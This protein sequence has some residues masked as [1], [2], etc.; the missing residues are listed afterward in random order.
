MKRTVLLLTLCVT[1][2]LSACGA[3]SPPVDSSQRDALLARL[4]GLWVVDAEATPEYYLF[5]DGQIYIATQTD[6]MGAFKDI[7]V[8]TL[9]REGISAWKSLKLQYALEKLDPTSICPAVT[10][11]RID[12]DEDTVILYEGTYREKRITVSGDSVVLT[13]GESTPSIDKLSDEADFS[14]EKF[15]ALFQYARKN[16]TAP[17]SLLFITPAD[18]AAGLRAIH[19]YLNDW[20]EVE[21]TSGTTIFTP[22]TTYD[23]NK[24]SFIITDSMVSLGMGEVTNGGYQFFVS[25]IPESSSSCFT[26]KDIW[27]ED[28]AELLRYV[29]IGLR[30]FPSVPDAEELA[31]TLYSTATLSGNLYHMTKTIG[32]VTYTVYESYAGWEKTILISVADEIVLAPL[33][34]D[35]QRPDT[36]TPTNPETTTPTNP[37]PTDPEPTTPK[38]PVPTDPEPTAPACDH[39]YSAATCTTAKTCSLCGATEGK[40]LGHNYSA[41]TCT[42]PKTCSD[43]GSTNGDVAGHSWKDASCTEPATCTSCG[44]TSGKPDGHSLLFTKCWRCDASDF[45]GIAKTYTDIACYDSKTGADY[46]VENVSIS[47]SGVLTFTFRGVTYSLQLDQTTG[48][49]WEVYFDC[50]QNGVLEPDAEARAVQSSKGTVFHLEWKYLDGCNLYFALFS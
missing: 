14:G 33:L 22:T 46:D 6:I 20:Y 34:Q 13:A 29:T 37:T 7:L 9:R 49:S 19:P 5:L 23:T 32:G 47:T 38:D 1:L 2:L 12:T 50:Y 3:D 43:C 30:N 25:Y 39:Q 28:L 42:T 18:Y 40:A 31:K 27:G 48:D 21:G 36:T 11:V 35:A 41:A 8:D 4:E 24:G 26:V 44:K 10:D 16:C 15:E 17:A 45:S